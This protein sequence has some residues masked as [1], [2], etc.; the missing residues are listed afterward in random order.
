MPSTHWGLNPEFCGGMHLHALIA[1]TA[2]RDAD[3][4][5]PTPQTARRLGVCADAVFNTE[6]V[7]ELIPADEAHF[8][9]VRR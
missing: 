4:T 6:I 5:K 1:Q 2:A 7:L 9:G 3:E 8:G